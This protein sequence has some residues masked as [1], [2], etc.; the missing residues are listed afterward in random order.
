MKFVFTCGGTAGHI[1]PA[2]AV[3][4]RLRSSSGGPSCTMPPWSMTSTRLPSLSAS[5][6]SWVT[7]NTVMPVSRWMRKSPSAAR[8]SASRP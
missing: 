8:F 6:M 2:L 1:N 4:G 7:N 5:P 3:A